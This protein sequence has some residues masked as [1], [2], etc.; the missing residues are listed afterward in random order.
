M[1]RTGIYTTILTFCLLTAVQISWGSQNGSWSGWRGDGSGISSE[2]SVPMSWDRSGNIL[3]KTVVPG[4][5]SSSPI[6]SKGKVFLTTSSD[7]GKT[8]H[9]MCF[10]A[11]KGKL[12][13]DTPIAV[14]KVGQTH[15]YSGYAAPTPVTDGK[16]VYA[17]FESPGLVALDYTGK[18]L[19][20][21]PAGPVN[22]IYNLASSPVICGDLVIITVDHY[23]DSFIAGV[24]RS[25]GKIRWKTKRAPSLN[26]STPIVVKNPDRTLVVMNG[27]IIRAYD[28]TTGNEVWNCKGMTDAVSPSPVQMD[29][30]L[31]CTSGRNGPTVILDPKGT[32][33]VAETC[34]LALMPTGGPY[35]V[36]PIAAYGLFMVPNDNGTLRVYDRSGTFLFENRFPG[37]FSSSPVAVEKRILWTSER[38]DTY[39]F[40]IGNASKPAFNLIRI[41]SIGERVFASLAVADKKVYIRTTGQL[42]CVSGDRKIAYKPK[43]A[44][45]APS[46]ADLK[47]RILSH[48]GID[49]GNPNVA[50]RVELV[51]KMGQIKDP[52]AP[53]FLKKIIM[54]DHWDVSE[55]AVRT[56]GKQGDAALPV[57]LELTA[58]SRQWVRTLSCQALG[59]LANPESI[60]TLTK[61]AA[62]GDKVVRLA[63]LQAALSVARRNPK[64]VDSV[65]SI[66]ESL[67][68]D[69]EGIVRA[70]AAREAVVSGMSD[71]WKMRIQAS[72]KA[73]LS[74]ANPIAAANAKMSLAK[75]NRK[76]SK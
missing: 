43:V 44:P 16:V 22:N 30:L 23:G 2:T 60:P 48:P 49:E 51:D 68:K 7:S 56:L 1:T 10:D 67:F 26:Y 31:L 39:V 69:S 24:E 54:E 19:W 32:G 4:E 5:G 55:T 65:L 20:T 9:I 33:D 61:T 38:G 17:F 47:E 66:V 50:I 40:S 13:W 34:V 76:V 58:D 25:T 8:R 63:A 72:L 29:G 46:Y 28:A 36:S 37:Q 73:M 35:V 3:W 45:P 27:T 53:V 41:N 57:L 14:E 15:P 62:D 70:A 18:I 74:D 71:T 6:V 64:T 12:L 11:L 75:L 42:Y 52:D 21:C 59:V